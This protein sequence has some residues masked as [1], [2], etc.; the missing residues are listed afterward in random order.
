MREELLAG[1]NAQICGNPDS[2]FARVIGGEKPRYWPYEAPQ[3]DK[4]PYA[5][6]FI[7]SD[8]D[9]QAIGFPISSMEWQM[10]CYAKTL[11]ECNRLAAACRKLFDER[12]LLYA[13]GCSF[14]CTYLNTYGPMRA[15]SAEPY[16]TVITFACYL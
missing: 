16:Q 11:P 3:R 12:P 10:N 4:Y 14:T 8:S 1:I 7:V 6:S 9:M 5:V 13:P 15:D 2:D